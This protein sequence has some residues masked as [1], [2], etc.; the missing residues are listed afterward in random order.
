MNKWTTLLGLWHQWR[1]A[2]WSAERWS[3]EIG[4]NLGQDYGID[5]MTVLRFHMRVAVAE[6]MEGYHR[7]RNNHLREL[8]RASMYK[9][10]SLEE[11][12]RT[13]RNERH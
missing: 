4:V 10:M 9:D 1:L 11:I 2:V 5:K 13:M 8:A 6:V 7:D 12:V 3:A